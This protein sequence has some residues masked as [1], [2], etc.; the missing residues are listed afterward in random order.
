MLGRLICFILFCYALKFSNMWHCFFSSSLTL[1]LLAVPYSI[2]VSQCL[3]IYLSRF[4]ICTYFQ[5]GS[6]YTICQL[7]YNCTLYQT[8]DASGEELRAIGSW[9]FVQKEEKCTSLRENPFDV[10]NGLRLRLTTWIM[11]HYLLR[12][13]FFPIRLEQNCPMPRITPC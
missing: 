10:G 8:F 11:P 2:Q 6:L 3:P 13:Y 9:Y 1:A 5:V 7:L 12:V 4:Q